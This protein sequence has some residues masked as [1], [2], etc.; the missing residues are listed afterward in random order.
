MVQLGDVLG[1]SVFDARSDG[2]G[3]EKRT[4]QL[5]AALSSKWNYRL[6]KCSFDN[7]FNKP[8]GWGNALAGIG[9]LPELSENFNGLAASTFRDRIFEAT[10]YRSLLALTSSLTAEIESARFC[11]W[12]SNLPGYLLTPYVLKKKFAKRVI[13][14]PHNIESLVPFQKF[15]WHSKE[16]TAR[17]RTEIESLSYCDDVFVISEEEQWLLNLFDIPA[18]LLPF[19]P[20]DSEVEMLTKI[21]EQREQR[22]STHFLIVG[23]AINPPTRER[24]KSLLT[25]ISVLQSKLLTKAQ[26]KVIGF[27]TEAFSNFTSS[28]IIILGGVSND[29][30]FDEMMNCRAAVISQGFSTGSLTKFPELLIAGIPIISD[31]GSARSFHRTDGVNIYRNESEFV[32]LLNENLD[33][34]RIPSRPQKEIDEFLKICMY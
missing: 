11:M 25:M 16:P 7:V 1:F 13:A 34:P 29:V 32:E 33:P 3:G 18:K 15:K 30:L 23:S 8:I 27:G 14:C 10:R 17:L 28:G 19:F 9:C 24:M 21:R 4:A 12:E 2:H 22:R 20:S 6:I 26:F 31:E 5:K